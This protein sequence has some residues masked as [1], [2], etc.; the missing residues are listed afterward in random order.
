MSITCV[1]NALNVKLF[2]FRLK[3]YFTTF[4][5]IIRSVVTICQP[6]FHNYHVKITALLLAVYGFTDSC[7]YIYVTWIFANNSTNTSITPC[8]VELLVAELGL[9]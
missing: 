3:L 6:F 1:S 8:V 4:I 5:Y 7:N 2:A 9:N